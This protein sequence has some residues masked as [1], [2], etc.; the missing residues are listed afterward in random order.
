MSGSLKN[1]KLLDVL[2]TI[3]KEDLARLTPSVVIA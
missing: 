2:I 1:R 3:N